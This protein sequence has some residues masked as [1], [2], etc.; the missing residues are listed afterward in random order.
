M[1]LGDWGSPFDWLHLGSVHLAGLGWLL[2]RTLR[3]TRWVSGTPE[4]PRWDR[5]V[6]RAGCLLLATHMAAA[7]WGVHGGDWATAWHQTAADTAR[8]TGWNSGLGLLF[9]LVT[10]ALWCRLACPPG[11]SAPP[12]PAAQPAAPHHPGLAPELPGP[13]GAAPDPVT[14]ASVVHPPATSSRPPVPPAPSG[15]WPGWSELYLAGMWFMA[16]VVFPRPV[17][18]RVAGVCCVLALG[19]I[20]V[21]AVARATRALRPRR[22]TSV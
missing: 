8:V 17:V 13:H 20:A 16:A 5:L 1:T 21:P 22:T 19:V 18:R 7:Y 4:T 15:G 9:N 12:Q 6:D 11:S 14:S 3:V 10:L 2:T